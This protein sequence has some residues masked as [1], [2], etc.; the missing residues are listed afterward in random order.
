MTDDDNTETRKTYKT[1]LRTKSGFQEYTYL[2]CPLTR[3]RTPWCFRLCIPDEEG[4]GECGR[5]APHSFKSRI[6][7][8]IESHKKKLLEAHFDKL[9]RMY[10]AAECNEYYEPGIK[11]SEGAA[12]IIIP[13]REKFFH[14]GGSVHGSVFFKAMDDSAFFAVNSTVE[15][16]FVLTANFHVDFTRPVSTGKIVA[17]GRFLGVSG[18]HFLAESVLADSDGNEIGRGS[19]AFVRS[20]IPLSPD[21]GYV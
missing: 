18:K 10:V 2:G 12:E 17:K 15:D 11:I 4:T 9:E 3:N 13:V 14:A 1:K 7:L 19:G 16:V 8:G 5:I 21:I 20:K 6:Q